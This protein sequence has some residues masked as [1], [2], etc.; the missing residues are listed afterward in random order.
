MTRLEDSQII[1]LFFER[2]EQAIAELDR[3]YGPAVRKTAANILRDPL[4]AEECVNDAYLGTWNSIPPHRPGPLGSY[5]CRI[6]R[7]LAIS[8]YRA[9]HAAKRNGGFELV[10][11]EL[12]EVVP[13]GVDLE[14]ELEAR[15]LLAAVGRFLDTLDR[16]DRVLF[17]RRYWFADSVA[18]LAAERHSRETRL[19]ARLFRL[20]G[21]LRNYLT[22]EGLL[23]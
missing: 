16:D 3:K 17:V 15:E 14:K 8:R 9:D 7:N 5:V 19:S 2:S 11:D 21:K 20:R 1:D 6:A 10:L 23:T 12:A 22:K 13:S 18:A 4:D